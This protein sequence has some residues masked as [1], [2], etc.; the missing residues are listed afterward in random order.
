[1]DRKS[2]YPWLALNQ[3]AGLG[4]VGYAHLIERFGSPGKVF[5]ADLEELQ[6]IEGIRKNTALA[7]VKF[8]RAEK[9][10]RELDELE[11]QKVGVLTSKDRWYPSLLAKIHDPPPYLYYK[12]TLSLQDDRSLAVVGSRQAS[13]Y[14]IKVTERLTWALS[15]KSLTIVSGMARGIDAA[16]HQGALMA[17]GRTVAVLGSGLDVIY[18][19]E[20]KK[21][22]DRIVES[23]LVYSEFPLGTLPERQNFPIRNRI[24]SGLSLGVVIVEATQRSGSL[25]TARLALDQGREVFAVPGSV[26]SFKSSGTHSLIKQ[27]AKLVEHAQDILEELHWDEISQEN[28]PGLIKVDE[29][30]PSLPAKEKQVWDLLSGG[31]LHVD[32]MV[33][34]TGIGISPLLSLLLEMELKGLIR[35]LPGKYFIRR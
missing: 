7:I 23:G 10:D 24:I 18:P 31:S 30:P 6:S 2:L 13:P 29:K 16:A 34:Q 25:I 9:I 32:Q 1:M 28:A 21:L 3:I 8:K 14:G 4:K 11:R 17:Q 15:Q 20:N 26:E 22:F 35:Q 12:G 27:G 19:Q 5:Q 33:R